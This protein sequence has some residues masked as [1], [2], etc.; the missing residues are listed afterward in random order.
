MNKTN[1][2]KRRKEK[3]ADKNVQIDM[4]QLQNKIAMDAYQK[5]R[6]LQHAIL[7]TLKFDMEVFSK[8]DFKY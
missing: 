6:Q 1:G 2:N 7:Q 4:L 8:G 5:C 3:K